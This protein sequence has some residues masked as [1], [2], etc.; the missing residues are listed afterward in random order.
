MEG[1]VRELS[2]IG[3]GAHEVVKRRMFDWEAERYLKHFVME[4]PGITRAE[5]H[6]EGGM[7]VLRSVVN[8]TFR[9]M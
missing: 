3:V 6:A 8:S 4:V 7:W 5:G 2:E 1:L 9:Y